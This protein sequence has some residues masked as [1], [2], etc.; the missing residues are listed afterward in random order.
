MEDFKNIKLEEKSQLGEVFDN[1]DRDEIHPLQKTSPVDFNTNLSEVQISNMMVIEEYIRWGILDGVT[2]V[3]TLKRLSVSK[4]GW[5][6]NGKVQ[7]V[8]GERGREDGS[9]GFLKSLF[10]RKSE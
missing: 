6:R 3:S 9:G 7:I 1:L 4:G 8:V 2:I 10:T 5:G